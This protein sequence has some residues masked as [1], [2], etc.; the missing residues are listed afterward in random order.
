MEERDDDP[1][2]PI[3]LMKLAD[4]VGTRLE[5]SASACSELQ[6]ALKVVETM[7]TALADDAIGQELVGLAFFDSFSFDERSLLSRWL[8][9]RSRVLLELLDSLPSD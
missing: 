9:P 3:I 7:L 6:R 4:F 1:G 5:S 8:G 2:E